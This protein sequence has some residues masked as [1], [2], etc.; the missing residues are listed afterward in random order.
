MIDSTWESASSD[1]PPP[2][3]PDAPVAVVEPIADPPADTPLEKPDE[4]Q[5][6][7]VAAARESES[8]EQIT[9]PAPDTPAEPVKAAEEYV[10]EP[11]DPAEL[12]ALPTAAAK[13]WAKRQ[14]K[15]AEPIR[16]FTNYDKPIEEFGADL[17]S[18]SQSRYTAHV[19]DLVARHSDYVSRELFGIPFDEAKARLQ[20]NGQPAPTTT[21]ASV[22]TTDAALPTPEEL[23]GM[24]NEDVA[25]RFQEFQAAEQQ[26]REAESAALK[27]EVAELKSQFEA[28]NGKFT[29][30]EQQAFQQKITDKQN[31][32]LEKTMKVVD[33]GIREMGLEVQPTDPPKLATLKKTALRIINRQEALRVFDASEDNQK[34]V[35]NV[36]DAINRGEFQNADREED[37]LAVRARAALATLK[38]SDEVKALL[39]EIEAYANQSKGNSRGANPAPPAPGSSVGITIKPPTT[40]DEA[41]AAS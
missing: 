20:P 21:A 33:A 22:T 39:D 24:S 4:L 30:Q 19:K 31:E 17:F 6:E 15:E 37:N 10:A 32:M 18:R 5:V 35:K 9:E 2:I 14:F 25:Q 7:P 27:K 8:T 38:N 11:D 23:A 28:V 12:S 3:V 1:A 29:T 36:V 13:K 41:V 34:L 26:K 40:W 16:N